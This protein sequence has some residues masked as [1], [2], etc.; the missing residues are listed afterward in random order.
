[1][2]IPDN[3]KADHLFLL[4]GENPLP[5]YVAARLLLKPEGTVYLVHTTATAGKDKPADLLKKELKKHNITT[6]PISL[7]DAESDGDKI[8]AKIKEEIKPKGKP[9]LQGKVGLNYTG[10]TKA[11][12]VHAYQA[13]QEL[14]LTEPVFSYL[15]SRK[16]AIHI[17]GKDQPIPVA[18]ELSPPPTLE[19]ILGLHNLSWKK[20][21]IRQSQLPEI[22]EEFSKLHLDHHQAKAWR[23]WCDTVFKN[24]KNPESYWKK[25]TQFPKPP[26]LK[27]SVTAQN[28]V[29]DEIQ[30]ILRDQGW[31]ST[32][33]LSLSIAKDQAKFSTFGD[34]CQWLDGGWLEDYV[35]SKVE[36]LAPKYSIRDSIMSLHIKDPRN[37]NR[38]TDQF[39]FDVAFLRGY[40]LFGISCTTSS[41]HKMC[42]QKLFEAQ[43]RAKQLGGNEARVALVCCYE[44]PSEWLKKELNFVVDDRKIEV[45][46]RQDLEPSEFTK[47]LDQWIYR[48]A[49]K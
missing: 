32:S 33:E 25:D 24:L 34:A 47:K 6:K 45:F 11:M 48:N 9:P 28:K 36:K 13:L 38:Q 23:K 27:L 17:D 4:I 20:E 43:L 31:A 41:N 15:D 42:K 29:P 39:E 19:T 30:K 2:T 8:R 3:Y 14:D 46:G 5:N 12:S 35:L 18:L 22:S 44:S 21:P 1:M 26:N 16:L 10:G 7:G 40:Q 37:Q 49:G